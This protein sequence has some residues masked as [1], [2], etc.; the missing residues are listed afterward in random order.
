MNIGSVKIDA[1]TVM[2]PMAGITNL[3]F[4]SLVKEAGCGLVCSEM[5]SSNALVY[6][7]KKTK[8]LLDSVDAERPLSIQVFGADPLITEKAAVIIESKG[9]D[10]IDINFGCSV[11]K[12][13]KSGA[14]A[15]LMK[16][17]ARAHTIIRAVRRTVSIPLTIKIRT[18][19]GR[20]SMQAVEIAKIAEDCGVDAVA[21]HPRTVAQGFKGT[22]DWSVISEVKKAVSIPVIGNG[23]IVNYKDAFAM[24]DQTGCDAVMIGRAAIG[25]PWIFT[26]IKQQLSGKE[27]EEPDINKRFET[28]QRYFEMSID[29]LGE[30]KACFMMR[31]RLCWFVKGLPNSSRFRKSIT[32]LSS[33]KEGIN[34]IKQYKNF[35]I[36]TAL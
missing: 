3:P 14:G 7:S 25:N 28:I 10:I 16:D 11:R 18:G 34:L 5:V 21:V 8:Q 20:Y 12:I 22:A 35:V 24:M 32:K 31:S 27:V 29:Y 17:H 2:A 23:D 26:Q 15:A 13:L 6:K 36:R 30:K 9:A 33:K 1:L 19:W 4:R